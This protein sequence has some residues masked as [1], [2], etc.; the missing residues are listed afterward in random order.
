[1]NKRAFPTSFWQQPNNTASIS[2]AKLFQVLSDLENDGDGDKC[3][4]NSTEGRN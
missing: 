1:M 3:D 2:P 4:N